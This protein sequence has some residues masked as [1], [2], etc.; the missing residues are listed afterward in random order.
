MGLY[1][2]NGYV[3]IR[4]VLSS[5][6]PFIFLIGGRATGKTYGALDYAINEGIYFSLIRRTQT[7]VELL[8]K[9][10]L[11]PFS[12]LNADNGTD[13]FL[14]SISKQ[15]TGIFNGDKQI[16]YLSALSTFSNLRG[17][18]DMNNK[19]LIYDEFIPEVHERAINN[20][21]SAFF[22]MY[23]TINRNRELQGEKPLQCLL[24]SNSNFLASPILLTLNLVDIIAKMRDKVQTEYINHKTGIAIFNLWNSPISEMKKETAL[25]RAVKNTAFSDMAINNLFSEEE[26]RDIKS[27]SLNGCKLLAR[28]RDVYIYAY[29]GGWYVSMHCS[30]VV[31]HQYEYTPEDIAR[32]KRENPKCWQRIINHNIRY[33]NYYCKNILRGI[34]F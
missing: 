31:K 24:L 5:N 19:L 3:N 12:A 21:D 14:K 23:E 30:G 29:T 34:Y 28:L 25:Y 8:S 16:G 6:C 32:F 18:S 22:N 27:M 2:E 1:L 20:E 15:I 10:E 17:F 9:P 11:N 7:Q 26:T 13:I 4:Y 33:E